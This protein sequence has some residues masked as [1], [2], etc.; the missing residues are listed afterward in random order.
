MQAR[1]TSSHFIEK[2]FNVLSSLYLIYAKHQS[3][4]AGAENSMEFFTA[5]EDSKTQML[6]TIFLADRIKTCHEIL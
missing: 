5:P 6:D 1:D 4:L 2:T 3:W